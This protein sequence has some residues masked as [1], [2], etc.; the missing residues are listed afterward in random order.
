MYS[1][2]KYMYWET[3]SLMLLGARFQLFIVSF[4]F[5]PR[6]RTIV[7]RALRFCDIKNE[8]SFKG[9]PCGPVVWYRYFLDTN[10]LGPSKLGLWIW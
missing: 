1:M 6:N 9:L 5:I 8:C 10:V 7:H 2:F 4:M 3:Y